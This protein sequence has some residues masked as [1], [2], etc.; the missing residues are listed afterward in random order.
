MTQSQQN[1]ESW[2]GMRENLAFFA[3]DRARADAIARAH[4]DLTKQI[5]DMQQAWLGRFK[6][7]AE[8]AQSLA[9]RCA[10]CSNPGEAAGLYSEW[11][12]ERMEAFFADSRRFADQWLHLFDAAMAPLRAAQAT[13]EDKAAA[14]HAEPA[15]ATTAERSRAARA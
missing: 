2:S 8:S 4:S 11:V 13:A 1:N 10:K 7:A 3:L 14:H 9:A 6:G 15:V 5:E 12:G